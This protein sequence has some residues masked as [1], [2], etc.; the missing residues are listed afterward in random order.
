MNVVEITAVVV[1]FITIGGAIVGI[2]RWLDKGQIMSDI[3]GLKTEN[4]DLQKQVASLKEELKENAKQDRELEKNF[5]ALRSSYDNVNR[6]VEEMKG[7]LEKLIDKLETRQDTLNEISQKV[8]I[9][10]EKQNNS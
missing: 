3:N 8:A 4:Q 6:N 5:I 1:A 9:L 10:E 2:V 7:L